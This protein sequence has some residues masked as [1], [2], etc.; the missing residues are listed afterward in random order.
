MNYKTYD[1]HKFVTNLT[2]QR[3]FVAAVS[4]GM[5]S[6]WLVGS[7]STPWN[8][9]LKHLKYLKCTLACQGPTRLLELA[10][11]IDVVGWGERRS[12]SR[13]PGTRSSDMSSK[14]GGR[15]GHRQVMNWLDIKQ[16]LCHMAP[17]PVFVRYSSKELDARMRALRIN[18]TLLS[19][20]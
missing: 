3:I 17:R 20:D 11:P 4:S 15:V 2:M 9:P 19:L 5:A 1:G 12:R 6:V 13:R 18:Q 8:I 14:V 16:K 7:L 10:A